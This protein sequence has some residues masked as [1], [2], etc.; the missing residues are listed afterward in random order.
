MLIFYLI[1]EN[2]CLISQGPVHELIWTAVNFFLFLF[3]EKYY[4][5]E[6]GLFNQGK[7][8]ILK[9][10]KTVVSGDKNFS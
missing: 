8:K 7:Q 9:N 3:K 2:D 10:I 1:N 6:T 5:A 4:T